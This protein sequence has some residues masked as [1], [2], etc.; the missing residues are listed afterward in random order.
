M[1]WEGPCRAEHVLEGALRGAWPYG[2]GLLWAEF[3]WVESCVG[4][5]FGAGPRAAHA[6]LSL[7]VGGILCRGGGPNGQGLAGQDHVRGAML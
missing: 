6:G 7:V 4:V 1:L 3:W 2:R 5:A